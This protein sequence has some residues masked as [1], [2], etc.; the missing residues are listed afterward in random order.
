[1]ME[2]TYFQT[3]SPEPFS[4]GIGHI[5]P[6]KLEKVW[7]L[8]QKN[9]ESLL[10][11]VV[12]NV[13]KFYEWFIPDRYE[14][15]CN[16]SDEERQSITLFELVCGDEEILLEYVRV[17]NFFFEENVDFNIANKRFEIYT[18][19]QNEDEEDINVTVCGIIHEKNFTDVLKII[20]QLCSVE[21]TKSAKD[22]I[23]EIKDKAIIAMLRKIENAKKKRGGNKSVQHKPDPLYELGNVVSVVSAYGYNNIG[24][25]N[26]SDVTIANLYDQFARIIID[27]SYQLSARNVSVW[28]DKDNQFKG[29]SYLKNLNKS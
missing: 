24:C 13:S 19:E 4:I 15:Y 1:M 7:K 21:S 20:A 14:E 16:A 3:L 5:I 29:D 17:F 26:I 27:R 28:G 6:P 12:L 22:E 23:A 25:T 10:F 11:Y 9:Y 18:T 8:G 2:L